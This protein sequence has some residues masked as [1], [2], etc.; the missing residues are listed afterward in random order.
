MSSLGEIIR[1]L[2]DPANGFA[3]LSY[4]FLIAAMLMTSL[5]WLRLLAL[6]SGVAAMAH[7]IFRTQDNASLVW[8][9]MFVLANGI[10]LTILQYRSRKSGFKLEERQLL[11]EILNIDDM[12]AQRR[13]LALLDWRDAGEG[14]ILMRQGEHE[15][16]LIY[17]SAGAATVEVDGRMVSAC[18]AGDFLGEISHVAGEQASATVT[19]S[20]TMRIAQFNREG[21]AGIAASDPVIA[22]AVDGA[23]NRSLAAKLVRMNAAAMGASRDL[24]E[25]KIQG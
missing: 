4:I 9:T 5:R 16:P 10:Q 23:L 13:V 17:I 15:P 12:A 21:L 14:T 8:E 3:H 2:A 1:D 7:F 24:A 11:G 19:V 20:N 18:G 6:A 25:A 22:K